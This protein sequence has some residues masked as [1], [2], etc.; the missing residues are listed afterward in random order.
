ME[1]IM[2][3]FKGF[4]W[5]TRDQGLGTLH[6]EIPK[7]EHSESGCLVPVEMDCCV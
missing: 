7:D 1:I 4:L 3:R 6:P 5:V 2:G